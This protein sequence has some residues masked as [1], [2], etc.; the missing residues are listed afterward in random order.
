MTAGRTKQTSSSVPPMEMGTRVA[1]PVLG[2]AG[3][4]ISTYL[5]YVHYASANT[6]CLFGAKCDVVLT[7]SYS[8][9]WGVPL[10][11]FG[12]VMYAVITAL[13]V[14][15][16]RSRD[17]GW[18]HLIALGTYGVAL[19]GIVFTGYL[20]CLEIF[21]IHAFCS[22]CII[23][24]IVLTLILILSTANFFSIRSRVEKSG[25]ARRFKISDLVG[26]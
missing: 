21:V 12:L 17:S 20:Y 10:A 13:G 7:S 4:A 24:S 25:Q 11:L 3:M 23:S 26:W 8:S 16:W 2:L 14:W 6:I 5:T 1:V 18:E 15:L 22:W 9:M 19:A